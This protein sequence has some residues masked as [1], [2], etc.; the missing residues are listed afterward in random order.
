M[1][2]GDVGRLLAELDE[3]RSPA[4]KK[5]TPSL[6]GIEPVETP[7][8]PLKRATPL[9]QTARAPG[10]ARAARPNGPGGWVWAGGLVSAGAREP[11]DAHR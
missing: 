5:R 10:I 6:L 2:G 3:G 7:R 1:T 8:R 11:S 4:V 9:L